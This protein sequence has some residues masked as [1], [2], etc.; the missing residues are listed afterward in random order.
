MALVSMKTESGCCDAPS[1]EAYGYGLCLDLNDQQCEALGITKPMAAGSVV[2]ISAKAF[3]RS[4]T[5]S[6]EEDGEPKV[7]MSLQITD[8]EVSQSRS[9]AELASAMFAK[10]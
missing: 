1:T 9:S 4:A 10:E 6:A 8:M 2:T 5:E 3:V 7:R